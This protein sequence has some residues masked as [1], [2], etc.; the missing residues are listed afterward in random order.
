M[1]T[2]DP[3]TL[4]DI[5]TEAR[6][7]INDSTTPFRFPN[8]LVLSFINTAIREL[9]RYR[10]DAFIGNFT[11]GIVSSV[12]I[13][14]Y[15]LTDLGL[16]PATVLPFDDRMFFGPVV[17]YVAGR[18]ELSDDEFTDNGRAMTLMT[19]FRNMLITPGG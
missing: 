12:A 17:F 11:S 10:P 8:V 3:K 18:L 16:D 5:V 13:P 6:A 15:D 9:Y 7:T 2:T 14:T 1:S 19:A 4:D